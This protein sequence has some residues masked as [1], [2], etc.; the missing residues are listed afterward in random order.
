MKLSN[1]YYIDKLRAFEAGSCKFCNTLFIFGKEKDGYLYQ[2]SDI[3]IYENYGDNE[4][5]NVD[6]YLL[7]GALDEESFNANICEEHVL[8]GSCGY[9][10][11]SAN[12]NAKKCDCSEECKIKVYKVKSNTSRNNISECPCCG[13]HA[14]NGIV[15]SV[16][17]G[18][19]EATAILSQILY[20]AIDDGKQQENNHEIKLSFSLA[21]RVEEKKDDYVKQFIAFSDSRQ[22]ASFFASFFE[23]NHNNFLRKRLIWDVIEK[24]NYGD[25]SFDVLISKLEKNIVNQDLFPDSS[26]TDVKQA[27][28]TALREL[29]LVDGKY[30]AE[31]LGLFYFMLDVEPILDRI[32]DEGIEYEF[33]KYNINKKDLIGVLNV[34]FNVFRTAT[35]IDYSSSGLNPDERKDFLGYRKF[36]NFVKLQKPK[37]LKSQRDEE[38]E[39]KRDGNIRSLL[40]VSEKQNNTVVDYII[41]TFKC[42]RE[43]AINIITLFY[44]VIGEDAQ[45]FEKSSKINDTVYQILPSKYILKN[46]KNSKFYCCSKCG[47]LTPYNVHDVCPVNECN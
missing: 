1:H 18:K 17:I 6:Y 10:Y 4:T 36:E 43:T 9:V 28:V 2:N 44:K 20:K 41:R 5:I 35:A 16:N 29:L 45:L 15:R 27:W 12:L 33:G 39:F 13:H 40:P 7:S 11:N 8:C 46:Y 19:D 37:M 3:D 38:E 32:G 21:P 30:S 34:I 42:D 47:G 23:S 24:N 14:A 25:I 22:Q 31:G 26:I